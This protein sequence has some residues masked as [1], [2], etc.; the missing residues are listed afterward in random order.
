MY[1]PFN[2]Q[3]IKYWLFSVILCLAITPLMIFAQSASG[4]TGVVSDAGGLLMPGVEV[5]LKDTKTSREQTAT[6]NDQGVYTFSNIQP[7]AGYTLTFTKQGFQTYSINQVQLSVAKLET[8]NAQMTVGQVTETVQVTSTSGD[9]TLNTTDASVGNVIGTRQLRE[10][11]IQIR[12]SPAA[13]VGLQ[14]G[15]I[16]NNV[17]AGT[18]PGFG[19]SQSNRVGSITGARADQGNITVD[20]I[21]SNDQATGQAFLTI[22]NIAIDSVQEFRAV[23]AIPGAGEGRSSGGQ[24]QIVTKSGTNEFH[25]SLREYNRTAATA[26]NTYFNNRSGLA[27][28]AL[29]RNQFGGSIGGPLPF[30]NFGEGGPMFNSGKNKSFFFFDYEGWR[31]REAFGYT[32]IVPLQSFRSG[33][34]AYLNNT[35]GC[36]ALSVLTI[37]QNSNSQCISYL[38]AAQI[39]AID[40]TGVGINQALLQLINNRYPLAND[41]S[42]GD[43]LN[44]GGIRFNAP[45]FRNESNYTTRI[46]YNINSDQKIFGRFTT[47][48]RE[49]SDTINAGY[50][51]Q[52]PGDKG[53]PL[54]RDQ[55]FSW[56]VG[57]SWNISPSVFN[58]ITVGQVKQRVNFP[59]TNSPSFPN[60][61]TI[62]GMDSPYARIDTQGRNILVP[63]FADDLT[64]NAGNHTLSFGAV[65][66]PIRSQTKLANDLNFVTINGNTLTTALRPANIRPSSNTATQNFDRFYGV[67]IGRIESLFT[68]YTY[69]T[70]G[71]ALPPGSGRLRNY[72]YDEY[73]FYAQ[74]NWRIRSD[75]NLNFGLRWQ[76]YQPPYERDGLQGG[77]SLDFQTLIDTRIKNAANGISGDNAEPLA[78]YNLIGE[79][80]NARS[81]Y[82]ADKNNFA[83]R[84]GFAWNPA[85]ESGI[86]GAIFG[87]RKTSLRGGASLVYDRTGGAVTF[88]QDQRTYIFDNNASRQFFSN[89]AAATLATSP[90]FTGVTTLPVQNTAPVSTRPFTPDAD[91]LASGAF[92]YGISENY[93]IPYSY[94]YSF[95]IQRE[96]PGNFLL[97]VTW[98]G[99]KGRKLFVQADAAQV[100]NFKDKQSGQFLF[101]ALNRLQAQMQSNSTLTAQP[102]FENQLNPG[103]LNTFGGT[104]QDFGYANCSELMSAFYGTDVLTGDTTTIVQS[105]NTNFI[106]NNS[107]MSRQFASSLYITNLGKSDYNG[108]LVSLQKRFSQGLEFDF[109]YTWSHAID[110]QSSVTNTVVGAIL[111]DVTNP[112][113]CRGNSDFDIH[114]LMNVNGIYELPIGRGRFFG[115]E[116][117]NWL[118]AIAGGWSISGIFVAR[119][120]LA[121]NSTSQSYPV[122]YNA[123]SPAMLNGSNA[124]FKSRI[125]DGGTGVQFFDNPQAVLTA[126]RYPKHGEIG[127]RNI[128]RGPTFFNTDMAV[129]KKFKLP[130]SENQRLTFRAEA[131]N[132]FNNNSFDAPNLDITSPNFGLMTRA[133]TSPRE[134]QFALRFDF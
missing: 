3:K 16:G 118:D 111:C 22:G 129:S 64:W 12:N 17:G 92:N 58:K 9:A 36:T 62:T 72:I 70:Q 50:Q 25:G 41:F 69:D 35:A 73:E 76:Y 51:Q 85:F 47:T 96:L 11:P 116:M 20:G 120:G 81:I 97:D 103:L 127:N 104:C 99:R 100:L 56:V 102:W 121:L 24:I 112:N 105:L 90:R 109:N 57:H 60:S 68:N 78:S 21:D 79:A 110:N 71:K 31:N 44:T 5:K 61:Y 86:L 33:Q 108:M 53:G 29:V 87:N 43:G 32:R 40:P 67:M 133:L 49:S 123:A 39:A 55:S 7:G 74:D 98:V 42:L 63:T 66:K 37:R 4:V 125:H 107:G 27:K 80:N 65:Y 132:V 28:R 45:A 1:L 52:F 48:R 18:A 114:H 83:P 88:I 115:K 26:A 131:Y 34:I 91:G 84:I 113:A 54:I 94:Q 59:N 134:I 130:W 117:P 75:L 106:P 82:K 89:S 46:D 95:G 8:Y 119:S 30:F 13:L 6:T 93:K 2:N 10:L 14:P 122:N 124:T 19:G 15:A 38:S 77:N 101:D 23:T 126:L 128:F